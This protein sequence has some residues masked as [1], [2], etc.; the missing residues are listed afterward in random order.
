MLKIC[1]FFRKRCNHFENFFFKLAS[2]QLLSPTEK[3]ETEAQRNKM[4]PPSR[5]HRE[6]GKQHAPSARIPEG[7]FPHPELGL[8]LR[9]APR[10][11]L[12]HSSVAASSYSALSQKDFLSSK[13]APFFLLHYQAF[14]PLSCTCCNSSHFLKQTKLP[15]PEGLL[16]LLLH[17]SFP[18][19]LQ[20]NFL[21]CCWHCLCFL[22]SHS[23]EFPHRAPSSSP[24]H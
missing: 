1:L 11:G 19:N 24:F 17:F 18:F 16:H 2:Q 14:F 5:S 15:C 9:P 20:K 10:T 12:R 22:T 21:P 4:H 23:P 3:M 8:L 6:A 7:Y 13:N